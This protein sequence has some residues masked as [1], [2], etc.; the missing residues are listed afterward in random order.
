MP[1][2]N[3]IDGAVADERWWQNREKDWCASWEE[4]RR[5]EGARRELYL[6]KLQERRERQAAAAMAR[7]E[8]CKLVAEVARKR[9]RHEL[10]CALWGAAAE[11]YR[12]EQEA[13]SCLRCKLFL[14]AELQAAR[15]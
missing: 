10:D 6:R 13:E 7:E 15:C 14:Q 9:L 11:N 1:W 8:K 4:W 2:K 12:R 3:R 5:E